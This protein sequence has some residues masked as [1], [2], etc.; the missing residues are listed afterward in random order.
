MPRALKVAL[1]FT[2]LSIVPALALAQQGQIAGTVRDDQGAVMP[3]VVVEVT[4]P[5]LIEKVR[6]VVS[7]D[8]GQYRIT[9]LPVG[10]YSVTFA[11]DGFAKQQRDNIT[12]TSGFTA[13]VNVTMTV[14]Q[15]TES[16]NVVAEAP[17]V[18]VQNARQAVTFEG[19]ELRDLP[20]VRNV[21]S[22]LLLTPGLTAAG[23]GADCVG[24]AGVWCNNNIYNL[25]A[26]TAANDNDGLSQG[27]I[28]VD[29]NVINSGGGAGIMGITGGYSPDVGNAQE[30]SISISGA[31]GES[32]TGGA[33]INIVPRTGGNRFAG[34]YFTSYT[35]QS[36]FDKNNGTHTSVAVVNSLI[37]DHDIS[38]SFGGPILRDRLWFYASGR[39][40]GK[41]AYNGQ[42]LELWDNKNVGIWGMNY[43]P[44]RSTKP[45]TFTNMTRNINAR[46]TYQASQRN[47]FNFFWDEGMTCQD[48]CDG[49][50]AAWQPREGTWSGQTHPARLRQVS[51]TNPLTNRILL[52]AGLSVNT[53]LYDFSHHKYA[54]QHPEIPRVE[55]FGVTVGADEVAPQVNSSV[56]PFFATASGFLNNGLGGAA[57]WR[58]LDDYR[59]RAA[60]SYVT[61]SHN[62]KIGYDAAYFSQLR[63][64][65]V[66]DLR[67]TYRYDTPAATCATAAAGCGNTSLYFPNDP[68]NL[69][70]RPVPTR[71]T[72]NTGVGELGNNAGLGALYIQDQWTLKRF[73]LNG[74]LRYDHAFSSYEET[75]L[76]PDPYMPVQSGGNYAGQNRYCVAP[77]DGVSY[78]DLT[79]RWG[80]AWDVFGTG[81][82][83]IKWNMGKYLSA[84]GITGI[85]ADANPASRTVNQIEMLWND[86]NGDR[87][88]Q[89][90][91]MNFTATNN[92][93]CGG[94]SNAGQDPVRYGRDPFSFAAD[95][96]T[97]IGLTTTQCGRKEEGIPA[98][99]QAYC[100]VY[101]DTLLDGWGKRRAEWQFGL[102]IQHEVLPRL[103]AEVTF[104][105]RKYSNLTVSD[106][107]GIGCDQFNGAQDMRACQDD[108]LNYTSA[109]YDF[110]TVQA[111]VDPRL[112]GGGGYLVRGLTNPKATLPTGR[113]NAVT[114]MQE[115]EY[116]WNGVDTNFVW[117]GPW[118]IRANGGTS[119][120]RAVRD[121]C[122]TEVNAPNVKSREGNTPACNPHTRWDT[123]V[124]G[125]VTYTIPWA[126][127]LVSSIFQY[128]PGIELNA[129]MTV[130]KD[131]VT[132]EQNSA[133][134]A[135]AACTGAAQAG[136]VGCFV[137]Q[138]ATTATQTTVNLLDPG[139]IY[140]EGYTIFDLK[141]GKNIRFARKRLNVGVDVY[142]LFNNDA[143][144]GI[145]ETYPASNAGVVWSSPTVLL[146][147]RFARLS[148]QFDF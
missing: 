116:S 48:P 33:A 101:G 55:E 27:R 132:W 42:G 63:H 105:R 64:N 19:A 21:R 65:V 45:L 46:I 128:R 119:T 121:Q 53:Q 111:P 136:Q 145:Q 6:S 25:N 143:I 61:G 94:L 14:G 126:D 125:S 82:T 115:L 8:N 51:W 9:N 112:P 31:L 47:K 52:D 10:T 56:G 39:L 32:E 89:C 4:S 131:Q 60:A 88:P 67:W 12:L 110:F 147:P 124:R 74:A 5:A 113:P 38:G 90:D 93:E 146:S 11:L 103:S 123:N 140:G 71:I 81:K 35:R 41:E 114:I 72:I 85:Y 62:A 3:G 26:H 129:N 58:N 1:I 87:I 95:G 97:Q 78:N 118:G 75:C 2:A 138:G 83:S 43:Q 84:A 79:P 54:E 7:D 133:S 17:V 50:V 37:D 148:I 73:T 134:R 57:E 20:T 98:D 107:I 22:L 135:T 99:V 86:A 137:T 69:E 49:A 18:D 30:V 106:Q 76:G 92:G 77:T 127:I 40:W 141:F 91:L 59:W 122:H 104:N 29:G 66:N 96:I 16:V 130:T 23:L 70:R 15:R 100:S 102:G 144:R 68:T 13:P 80:V 142:N 36:W 108:A 109:T 117:R 120:G 44:D 139:D 34:N 28:M 24:G